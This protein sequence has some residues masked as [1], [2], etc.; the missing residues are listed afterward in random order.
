[1][2]KDEYEE[3]LRRTYDVFKEWNPKELLKIVILGSK[4]E[5]AKFRACA[6]RAEKVIQ[7]KLADFD[8]DDADNPKYQCCE[9]R[10]DIFKPSREEIAR[11][12][13]LGV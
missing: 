2:T 13:E 10:D 6:K 3:R 12:L 1:M 8:P 5:I 9:K 4:S 11:E 7:D